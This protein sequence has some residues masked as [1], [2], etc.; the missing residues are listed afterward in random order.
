[1]YMVRVSIE[2]V[3]QWR[4]SMWFACL[5][6]PKSVGLCDRNRKLQDWNSPFAYHFSGLSMKHQVTKSKKS[7]E[8]IVSKLAWV[9]K[10]SPRCVT[11][12]DVEFSRNAHWWINATPLLVDWLHH[13]SFIYIPIQRQLDSQDVN[14]CDAS[15]LHSKA[16]GNYGGTTSELDEF[17]VAH[18][19]EN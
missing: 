5:G 14:V 15:N 10:Y 1:M 8:G 4:F 9:P 2:L 17:S 3:L 16:T 7:W 13:R 19:C 11:R 18:W 12:M 6:L